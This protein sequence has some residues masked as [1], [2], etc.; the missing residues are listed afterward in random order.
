MRFGWL[1]CLLLVVLVT[2][3]A[4]NAQLCPLPALADPPVIVKYQVYRGV[5]GFPDGLS[6][7][8]SAD[9]VIQMHLSDAQTYFQN[10]GLNIQFLPGG[11]NASVVLDAQSTAMVRN[12][13][14]RVRQGP[15]VEKSVTKVIMDFMSAAQ[16]TGMYD[17]DKLNI[18]YVAIQGLSGL[19]LRR[20]DGKSFNIIVVGQQFFRE[21]LAHELSHAFS[22]H[23]V[24]FFSP[25]NPQIEYCAEYE[26]WDNQCDFQMSN[27]MWV[28]RPDANRPPRDHLTTGQMERAACNSTSALVENGDLPDPNIECPEWSVEGTCPK[29]H[30]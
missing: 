22:L 9:D 10:S 26:Y 6:S 5:N 13:V 27:L 2:P 8:L 20:H 30:P 4:A 25:G 23:H 28:R 16:A 15:R 7:T 12:V 29:L 24:N 14:N 1:I 3:V 11:W 18:Y 17:P 19:H 21:S